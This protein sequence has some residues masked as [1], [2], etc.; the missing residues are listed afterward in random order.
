MSRRERLRDNIREEIKTLARTQ[1]ATSGTAALSLGA[2][3]RAIEMVP[4]ALYCYYASRD[5]LI[6]ALIVDAFDALGQAAA[7]ADA[8]VIASDYGARM[9]ATA[10]AYR[11]WALANPADFLLIFGTPI[12]GY[13]APPEPTNAAVRRA[14]SVFLRILEAAHAAGVLH[15]P[16]E[17]EQQ[18]AHQSINLP[19]P[20]A[21]E[22]SIAPVVNYTGIACWA[23]MH[24][25]VILEVTNHLQPSIADTATFYRAEMLATLKAIGLDPH[26][27]S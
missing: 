6:T 19:Q 3:A 7:D 18:A 1:M 4:S 27:T 2:I 16:P 20:D 21:S 22:R 11:A 26:D 15:P 9:L 17:H 12:P 25:L 13:D 14:F 24:G 5:D 23:R 8:Q 10:R